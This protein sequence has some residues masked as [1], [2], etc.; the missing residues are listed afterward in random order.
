MRDQFAGFFV[1]DFIR[2]LVQ[3]LFIQK[4]LAE[5]IVNCTMIFE[6]FGACRHGHE[7]LMRNADG[8]PHGKTA[9]SRRKLQAWPLKVV[10]TYG[11]PRIC[12]AAG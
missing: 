12:Q 6:G 5:R 2:V 3:M 1:A 8:N 4:F 9:S 10:Q 11:R 7:L